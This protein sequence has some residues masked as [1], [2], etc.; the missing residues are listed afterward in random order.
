[1]SWRILVPPLFDVGEHEIAKR[2]ADGALALEPEALEASAKSISQHAV[3]HKIDLIT[4]GSLALHSLTGDGDSGAAT[5]ELTLGL[6]QAAV[7]TIDVGK[8]LDQDVAE[9]PRPLGVAYFRNMK[10]RAIGHC[11]APLTLANLLRGTHP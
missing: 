6:G 10:A 5:G 2:R 7:T 4:G 3:N 11:R 9:S 1:M 8:D